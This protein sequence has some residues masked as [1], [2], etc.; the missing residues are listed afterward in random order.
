MNITVIHLIKI[1][2]NFQTNHGIRTRAL[3]HQSSEVEKGGEVKSLNLSNFLRVKRD[4][5]FDLSSSIYASMQIFFFKN[6]SNF[7][8][9]VLKISF[10]ILNT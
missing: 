3:L 2:K 5:N 4:L 7:H 9:L 6:L 1:F 8:V 10:R